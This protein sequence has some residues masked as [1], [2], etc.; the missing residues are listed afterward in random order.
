LLRLRGEVGLLRNQLSE[1]ERLREQNRELQASLAKPGQDPQ[2]A[3]WDRDYGKGSNA[4]MQ[5]AMR[6]SLALLTYASKHQGQFP[7]NFEQAL[8]FLDGD[9]ITTEERAQ[10]T[11]AA[12]QYEILYTGRSADMTNP[13]PEGAI[14][15]RTKQPWQT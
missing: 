12:D 9:G 14:I 15:L 5:H 2:E 8:P 4:R 1:L 13:P 6:W 10:T 3:P 7:L 11:Q